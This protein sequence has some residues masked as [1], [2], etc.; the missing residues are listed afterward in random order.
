MILIDVNVLVYAHRADAGQH[1]RFRDWLVGVL[2]SPASFGMSDL[3]LSGF[4]R[5]VTHPRVFIEPTP[6][7][8]AIDFVERIRSQPNCVC[9]APGDRH[10]EIFSRLTRSVG[11]KGNL[12]PDAYFAALA[13]EHGA[14]WITTDRDFARFPDLGWRHPLS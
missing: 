8:T 10:W 12:I 9:I 14:E 5:I 11:A 6:L 2:N 4:M 1:V 3:A 13:I 7:D